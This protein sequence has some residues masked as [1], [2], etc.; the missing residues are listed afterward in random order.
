M[1]QLPRRSVSPAFTRRQLLYTAPPQCKSYTIE[2]VCAIP[3]PTPTNALASSLCMSHLLTGSDDGFIRD[4]DIW[5]AC[6]GRTYLTAPQRSHCGLGDTMM[7]A[8]ILRCW[9]PATTQEKYD[10][11]DSAPVYSMVCHSD[12]LWALS[13][14]VVSNKELTNS[15]T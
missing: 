11:G 8:G 12:A 13:G 14:S 15:Q 1:E 7:K 9:W 3:H 10:A 6:N 5:S 4:Y 2:P